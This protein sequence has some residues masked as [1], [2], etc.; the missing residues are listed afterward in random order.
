MELAIRYAMLTCFSAQV[1]YLALPSLL[2]NI[3]EYRLYAYRM[4]AVTRR[5]SP[6][7]SE[8]IGIWQFVFTS[9]SRLAIVVNIGLLVFFQNPMQEWEP[10]TALAAFIILEH[11]G[12]GISCMVDNFVKGV[13]DD[14]RLISE[15]N[16]HISNTILR[17][18]LD[19][20]GMK[21][22]ADVDQPLD[23]DISLSPGFEPRGERPGLIGAFAGSICAEEED[24]S[25]SDD[26]DSKD[27]P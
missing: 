1:P 12:L 3:V 14:V 5:T 21:T 27:T 19:K 18:K 25:S 7:P 11:I 15:F 8:G 24:D 13:P 23:F 6:F 17:E 22:G 16:M 26:Y 4:V 2:S 20:L 10:E 9:I